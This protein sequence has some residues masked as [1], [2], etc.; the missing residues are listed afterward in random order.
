MREHEIRRAL[1]ER[2]AAAHAQD[3][4]VIVQELGLDSGRIRVDVAVINGLLAGY[5]IKSDSDTL[6]R[7]PAQR[8]VYN[9]V[10]DRV[11]L[12][13]GP[14]HIERATEAIPEFWG[15]LVADPSVDGSLRLHRPANMNE[16][17][18]PRR[19]AQLLWRA[20]A[21]DILGRLGA[22]GLQR[23]PRR[24]LWDELVCRLTVD[25]L[26]AE[27][28]TAIKARTRWSTVRRPSSGGAPSRRAATSSRR[29]ALTSV[30][31]R[32]AE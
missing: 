31:S 24:V 30:R 17:R 25:E 19:L 8:D 13:A 28:R 11:M 7:L 15:I 2:L 26:A 21:A 10:F 1:L 3:G 29:L 32:I 18:N 27:V 6:L 12:V 14:R 4:S 20:E 22:D 23:A 16:H 9:D 5:E